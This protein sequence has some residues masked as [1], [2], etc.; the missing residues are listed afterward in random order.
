MTQNVFQLC[1]TPRFDRRVRDTSSMENVDLML[2]ESE[3][4]KLRQRGPNKSHLV[5]RIQRQAPALKSEFIKILLN[6]KQALKEVQ[7]RLQ[8]KHL[9][10]LPYVS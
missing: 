5:K 7:L 8:S 10:E 6:L 4:F 9:K 2:D 3:S 1:G